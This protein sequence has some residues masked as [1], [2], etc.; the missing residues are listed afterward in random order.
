MPFTKLVPT[1]VLDEELE[2]VVDVDQLAMEGSRHLWQ[3][4]V[5]VSPQIISRVL[6]VI[7]LGWN[8]KREDPIDSL[9]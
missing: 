1:I 6:V 8:L 3:Q 5:E 4:R 7:L 2:D 9:S